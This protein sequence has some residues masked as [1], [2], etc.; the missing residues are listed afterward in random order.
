MARSIGSLRSSS[1][2]PL[3]FGLLAMLSTVS[4]VTRA[5]AAGATAQP[6]D[7]MAI[8]GSP[9]ELI[10]QTQASEAGILNGLHVSGYGNQT[11]GMWQNPTALRD[12]TPSRNNLGVSR[13]LLQVDENYRFNENN[14]FFMRE[15]FVYEPPYSF[16]SANIKNYSLGIT[17]AL[18]GIT[19][20][21]GTPSYGHFMNDW[22]NVYSVRDAWWENKQGPLTLFVGN[23]TVVW[24]E[25]L[26]FRVG[27]V[28]NPT[29]TTWAFGFANLEQSRVPQWMIHPIL[30]VPELGPLSSNFIE[31]VVEPG[32]APL[33]Y[34][35]DYA[36]GRYYQ[37]G[38]KAGRVAIGAPSAERGPSSRFDIHYDNQ[39]KF[40]LNAPLLTGGFTAQPAAHEFWSCT[41]LAGLVRP[42]FIPKGTPQRNCN[43]GFSKNNDPLG[44]TGDQSLVDIGSWRIPGM[45]PQNWN[46][47]ARYHTLLGATELTALYYLDNTYGLAE[48]FPGSLRWTPF[49]NL[50]N[51]FY[52]QVNE[53]GLTANRPLPVPGSFSEVLPLI[54]RA[55]AVYVNHQSFPDMRPTSL[56]AVRYSDVVK[57][58]AAIDMDQAYAPWLTSTGN[59]T[60]NLEADD[61]ITMD[62]AKTMPFNGNDVSEA[63]NKNEVNLLFNLGTSWWW[64]DFEPTWTM[65]YNPKGNT[66]LLF[67]AIVLNPPWTKKYFMKLQAIEVLG[68]DRESAGGG[69][70]KGESLLT[71]QFQYNFNLL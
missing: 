46:V 51:Y 17:P 21:R 7:E 64:G 6:T 45:Q 25:S 20:N 13:S 56:S 59:L 57:W 61:F 18:Q 39:A 38:I 53:V 19:A 42:G 36:D 48:G 55:E 28:V 44:I 58:M 1:A 4:S 2:C 32:F 63:N 16:D 29:D 27:D 24:G 23:Q 30:N 11:F 34:E 31:A 60:A 69:L 14:T 65:I 5:F 62:N 22:N 49:T 41:Q 15:W 47:G 12:F 9:R 40:G 3:F 50:W 66:F 8:S 67:P 70:F 68:S 35:N 10:P 33:W 43:L 26:A 54:G 71:A 52:P 37:E